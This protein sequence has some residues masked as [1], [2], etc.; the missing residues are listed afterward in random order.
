M[1]SLR[2]H[3]LNSDIP[4]LDLASNHME[5]SIHSREQKRLAALLR[6]VREDAGLRQVDV[7][8]RL[9]EPQSFVSKY[10]SSERL[11]DLLELRQVC[12]VLGISLTD[13]VR[14]FEDSR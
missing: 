7:A 8:K 6:Q 14:Q 11:L 2:D 13:F 12:K 4:Q 3:I 9:G 5:K 10:E 1:S